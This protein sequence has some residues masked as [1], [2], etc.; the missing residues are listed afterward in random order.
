VLTVILVTVVCAALAVA[1][2]F[3]FDRQRLQRELKALRRLV[4]ID[5]KLVVRTS[6][7]FGEELDIQVLR[8]ERSGGPSSLVVFGLDQGDEDGDGDRDARRETFVRVLRATVRT[9]DVAY[10]TGSDE[11]TLILPDTRARGGL[12]AATRVE[13]SATANGLRVRAGVAETG[14]GLDRHTLF[15]NA[16]CALLSAGLEGRPPALAY[17]PELELGTGRGRLAGLADIEPTEGSPRSHR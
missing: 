12:V 15:R 6:E 8:V 14:P 1:L 4:R 16:Y 11:F 9:I 10:R 5:P 13:R 17:S 3:A 7:A 2:L